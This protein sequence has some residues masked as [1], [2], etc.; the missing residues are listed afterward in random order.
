MKPTVPRPAPP[1]PAKL[2]VVYC[3]ECGEDILHGGNDYQEV[4]A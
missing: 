4:H 2:H 1:K 3:P